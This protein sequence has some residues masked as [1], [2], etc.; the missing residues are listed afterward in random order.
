M[1]ASVPTPYNASSGAVDQSVDS[2]DEMVDDE[3][4]TAASAVDLPET[5]DLLFGSENFEVLRSNSYE[6]G[7]DDGS[8]MGEQEEDDDGQVNY[9]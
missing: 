7:S 9:T 2:K 6:Y 5:T 4:H 3:F 8:N 1:A